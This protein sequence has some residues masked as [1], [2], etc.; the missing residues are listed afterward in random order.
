MGEAMVRK[1]DVFAALLVALL[2][3]AC[4][5]I[6]GYSA[7]S[8]EQVTA[9]KAAHLKFIDTFTEGR[10]RSWEVKKFV[11][12]SDKVDLKLREAH[13]FAQSLDDKLRVS[14]LQLLR[15]IFEED[16]QN[17]RGKN[18][19]LTA[20]EAKTLAEPSGQAYDRVIKGECARPGAACK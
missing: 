2:V 15:E 11:E 3:G 19:L 14:N 1:T 6:G 12:E 9:L 8:H 10:D 5:L 4:A 18:R 13:E 20:I 16:A 7:R 17:M